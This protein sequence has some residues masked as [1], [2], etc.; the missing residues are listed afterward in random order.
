MSFLT[1]INKQVNSLSLLLNWLS[2]ASIVTMML[3]TFFDVV[4]RLFRHP[5]PGTY[6]MVGFA[7]AVMVS[8]SLGHTSLERGHI[9]VDFLVSKF[10]NKIQLIIDRVNTLVCTGLF[11]L[12]AWQSVFY[13][14]NTKKSGEVSMTL[15]MPVYPFIFGIAAGCGLLSIVLLLRF[16]LSFTPDETIV[17]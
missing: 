4:L 13:A 2:A 11:S 14:L 17:R 12:I 6:E 5:I 1:K 15:Q 16:L 8:F 9:A 3:L 10:P 7:G